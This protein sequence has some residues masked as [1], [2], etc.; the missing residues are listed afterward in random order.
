MIKNI[1]EDWKGIGDSGKESNQGK[2]IETIAEKEEIR[3]E[4]LG[5]RKWTEKDD[6]KIDNI[7][8]PYYEL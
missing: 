4:N 7:M 5:V 3:E 2:K 6:D 1:G 8:D